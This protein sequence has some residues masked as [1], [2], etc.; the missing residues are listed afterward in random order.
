MLQ[1]TVIGHD[2]RIGDYVTLSANVA[3]GGGVQIGD[4]AYVGLGA[5]VYPK[6][7]I[8]RASRVGLGSVVIR[9]IADGDTVS[10][11][12]ARVLQ[13]PV[14]APARGDRAL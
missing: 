5:M 6:I 8:G 7:K 12:A 4:G 9:D 3:M 13:L 14:E 1:G 11:S 2:S 10:G